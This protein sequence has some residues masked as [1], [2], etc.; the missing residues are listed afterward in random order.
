MSVPAHFLS[1]RISVLVVLFQLFFGQG[2][3][4]LLS[5][6][7][8]Q[9]CHFLFPFILQSIAQ[10]VLYGFTCSH[11]LAL[12][13]WPEFHISFIHSPGLAHLLFFRS[14][15][16][17]P[18]PVASG[19]RVICLPLA[20]LGHPP[21]PAS[22][23]CA[24]SSDASSDCF[25]CSLLLGSI[26]GRASEPRLARLPSSMQ[27]DH[28]LDADCS[29]P[30]HSMSFRPT[31]S[32][33]STSIISMHDVGLS[34]CSWMF[35]WVLVWALLLAHAFSCFGLTLLLFRFAHML[36]AVG[37]YLVSRHFPKD[38][39]ES[40]KGHRSPLSFDKSRSVFLLLRSGK[41]GSRTWGGR[42]CLQLCLPGLGPGFQI[43]LGLHL[44]LGLHL[45]ATS[46]WRIGRKSTLLLTSFG[47]Y[48]GSAISSIFLLLLL[49]VERFM[50]FEQA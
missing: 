26:R 41:S 28:P 7:S 25:S 3:S 35:V 27:R 38:C 22:P 5:I 8:F 48:H 50:T 43:H 14:V 24:T 20:D 46:C 32:A 1:R 17:T 39:Y 21:G 36:F 9:T 18:T 34:R 13:L 15:L 45:I 37:F 47:W 4:V 30:L 11:G 40:C 29:W 44:V 42:T 2:S 23:A 19:V 49:K 16:L 12:G 6:K 10:E 33:S 31:G